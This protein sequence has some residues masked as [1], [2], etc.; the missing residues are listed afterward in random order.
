MMDIPK[1]VKSC[2]MIVELNFFL[3]L[4]PMKNLD[5]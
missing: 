4:T 2:G 3:S 5:E 1:Y